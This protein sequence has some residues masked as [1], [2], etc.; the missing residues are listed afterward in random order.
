MS[1]NNF[2]RS[3]CR[4][5]IDRQYLVCNPQQSVECRLNCFP[6][7]YR[8]VAVQDFLEHLSVR[9]QTL[10]VADQFF[11]HPLRV[12]FVRMRCA[13]QIHGDIAISKNCFGVCT[14]SWPHR[15]RARFVPPAAV[16]PLFPI[17]I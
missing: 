10:A 11:K 1:H 12:G 15:K 17:L 14:A 8:N 7:I 6:T 13:D 3:P 16:G 9:N 2:L 5:C 4:G